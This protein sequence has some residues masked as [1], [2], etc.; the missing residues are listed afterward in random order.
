M[1]DVDDAVRHTRA[2]T[3]DRLLDDHAR[4]RIDL[5]GG[6]SSGG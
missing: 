2:R 4:E 3:K 1:G 6:A 5:L